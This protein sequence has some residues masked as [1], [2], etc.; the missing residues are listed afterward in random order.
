MLWASP[1]RR[2]GGC[3]PWWH[4]SAVVVVGW[5]HSLGSGRVGGPH[6][7]LRSTNRRVVPSVRAVA[8][9]GVVRRVLQWSRLPRRSV[10]CGSVFRPKNTATHM[11][12]CHP[13]SPATHYGL[14]IQCVLN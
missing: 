14:I 3:G 2:R 5:M 4:T 10:V 13:L 9:H 7:G 1:I 6:E 12:L 11:V 8:L